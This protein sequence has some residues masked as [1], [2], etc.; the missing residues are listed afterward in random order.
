[1]ADKTQ[2][3]GTGRRKNSVA[4][5]RL[6]LG[7]GKMTVNKRP[8]KEYFPRGNDQLIISQPL[9]IVKLEGKFDLY[10]IVTGKQI[11]RAHV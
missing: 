6:V 9:G 1:M 11:G 7:D 2:Y 8:L 4:R 10:V 3:I 5:V